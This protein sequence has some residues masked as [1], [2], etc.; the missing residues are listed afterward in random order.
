M[1]IT[2]RDRNPALQLRYADDFVVPAHRFENVKRFPCF[3]FPKL[4]NDEPVRKLIPSRKIFCA[5]LK[6]ALLASIVV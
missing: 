2:N 4:W 3:M 6:S 1:W 5:S